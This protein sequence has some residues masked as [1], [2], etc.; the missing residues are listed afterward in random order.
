MAKLGLYSCK[1]AA[2]A[3][4]KPARQVLTMWVRIWYNDLD[5]LALSARGLALV[6]PAQAAAAR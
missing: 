2:R 4:P 1:Q 3:L 6:L 5:A